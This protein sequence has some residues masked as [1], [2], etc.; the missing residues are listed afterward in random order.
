M[1]ARS[2]LLAHLNADAAAGLPP[3]G[4]IDVGHHGHPG[5][6]HRATS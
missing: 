3:S 6:I 4:G 2:P 1:L 5:P